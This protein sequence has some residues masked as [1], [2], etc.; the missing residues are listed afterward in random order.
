MI[1][2]AQLEDIIRLDEHPEMSNLVNQLC[3]TPYTEAD[4][5]MKSRIRE[6][7]ENFGII[8]ISDTPNVLEVFICLAKAADIVMFDYDAGNRTASWF[9]QIVDNVGLTE[10]GLAR[11]RRELKTAISIFVKQPTVVTFRLFRQAIAYYF[12]HLKFG[13]V[14]RQ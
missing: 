4:P 9:W 3:E 7:R 8:D 2:E 5:V 11:S 6:L 12:F 1:F 14:N 10:F 13:K